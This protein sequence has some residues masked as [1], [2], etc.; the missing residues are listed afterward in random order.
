MC[1]VHYRHENV[2][3]SRMVGVLVHLVKDWRKRSNDSFLI[4]SVLAICEMNEIREIP[5]DVTVIVLKRI[6]DTI[7]RRS[8]FRLISH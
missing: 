2:F 4:Q 3:H 1:F 5:G 6:G 8:S 7:S